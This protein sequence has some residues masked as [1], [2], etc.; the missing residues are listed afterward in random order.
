MGTHKSHLL[1]LFG[2]MDTPA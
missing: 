2:K 1:Q